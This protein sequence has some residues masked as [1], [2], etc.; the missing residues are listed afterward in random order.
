MSNKNVICE[1]AKTYLKKLNTI[2]AGKR[3][4]DIEALK[5]EISTIRKENLDNLSSRIEPAIEAL[6]AN[7]FTVHLAYSLNEAYSALSSIIEKEK[8]VVKS[9]SNMVSR[10]LHGHKI[11]PELVETDLGDFVAVALNSKDAHPVLPAVGLSAEK[12]AGKLQ[13]KLKTSVEPTP[14]GIASAVREYLRKKIY[15][16]NVGITGANAITADGSVVILE[17]E[18]NIS[19]VSR[20]VNT[21]VVVAGVEKVV[22]NLGQA[23]QIAHASAVFGTNQYMPSYVNV[24]SGPSKTADIESTT[25]TGAQG[26][27]SVH[28]ILID[29]RNAIPEEFK[30]LLACINC[31][32]CLD[33]CDA[34]LATSAISG[35]GKSQYKGIKYL[36]EDLLDGKAV[37]DLI[38]KCSTCRACTEIC[39]AGIPLRDI[40]LRLREYCV[41]HEIA[42]K[43]L[44]SMIKNIRK[45]GNPFARKKATIDDKLYCC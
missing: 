19:L 24:I 30:S 21:H 14:E 22:K 35:A 13:G 33:V 43:E 31:G 8:F 16:A 39:P 28:I 23:M 20:C 15:S 26:A 29:T 7:G 25:I 42:P 5:K 1:R 37:P 10:I 2:T 36:A 40:M 11:K 3:K 9:K 34:Y 6:E 44:D 4:V 12:I 45:T 17:N 38:F 32:A 41:E 27:R 18:G